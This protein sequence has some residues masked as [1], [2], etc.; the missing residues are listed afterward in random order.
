MIED[1][2]GPS[3]KMLTDMKFLD[4]LK[5]YD[6]DNINPVVIKKIREKYMTNP[7]FNPATIKNVSSACEGTSTSY[8]FIKNVLKLL[9]Q[10][11]TALVSSL[12]EVLS[13]SRYDQN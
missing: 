7:E 10:G 12:W 2:W 8:T 3:K 9:N 1:F 4:S 13:Y 5:Q 11:N 6:K